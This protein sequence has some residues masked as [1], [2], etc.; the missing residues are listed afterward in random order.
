VLLVCGIDRTQNIEIDLMLA[1][2]PPPLHHLV[3]G[4]LSAA[5]EPVGVVN[6]ARAID[7]Q[8]NQKTMFLEKRAPVVIEKDAVGLEG[9]LHHLAGSPVLL[10]QFDGSPEE[11]EFHQ[12]WLAALPRYCHLG[13]TVRLQQLP[14]VG[15]QRGLRHSLFVVRVERFLR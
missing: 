10:D 9:L 6:F 1:Q 13:R 11:V 5:V 15:L 7:A 14:D 4:A 2:F 3:E 8:A 12:R